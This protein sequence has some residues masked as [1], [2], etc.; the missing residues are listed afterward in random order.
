MRSLKGTKA[1]LTYGFLL[2]IFI[3]CSGNTFDSEEELVRFIQ[4][5]EHGFLH[6]K[7]I[8]GVD[9]KLL[10]KPT[11]L[12]VAQE[13]TDKTDATLRDSLRLKYGQYLYFNLSMS[14]NNK[15]LLNSVG[16]D[17][18]LFGSMVN[19]LAFG[20]GEKV[21]LVNNKRD[22]IPM[23]DYIY[24]RMYGMTSSTSML[25]VYPRNEYLTGEAITLTIEDFGFGTGEV[26]F[27]QRIEKIENQP[28]LKL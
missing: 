13:L 12:L 8:K 28:N 22:T 14:K 25:L 17:K 23:L 2:T 15:E 5:K 11:D 19:T 3:S 9:Y 6:T 24:P 16:G 4:D 26:R 21:H 1:F 20:M 7:S 27:V 10:Y 18:Q